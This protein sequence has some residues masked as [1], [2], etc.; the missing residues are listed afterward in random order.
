MPV[1]LI[2]LG[3]N[4]GDRGKNLRDARGLLPPEIRVT[5]ASSVY[6]TEPWGC[7]DQPPFLNQ[8]VAGETELDPQ[9]ALA[10]LKGIETRLGRVPTFR[11]GPRR[12]DLDILFYD[13]VILESETLILPHP[14]LHERVFV[15]MP[16]A[17]I[18]PGWLHPILRRTIAELL[19][20]LPARA[21]IR[22][23]T[24]EVDHANP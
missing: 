11:F 3:A 9:G 23:S 24:Q 1:I 5:R 18:A 15:L 16:L 20:D 13:Q 2:A 4:L 10:H 21:G 7:T 12:I 17:E 22:R 6:E 19:A 14:R 8:V